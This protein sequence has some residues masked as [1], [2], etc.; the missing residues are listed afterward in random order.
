MSHISSLGAAMFT[1]MSVS[2]PAVNSTAATLKA[3]ST[4]TDFKAFFATQIEAVGGVP[5]AGAFIS[6]PNVRE[7]PSIGIPANIVNV[8]AYGQKNSSQVQGQADAPTL[9]LT[10]NYVPMEWA[11]AT[12][13]VLGKMVGDGI[14]RVFRFSLLNIEPT[15]LASD[16]AG[17]GTVEN[18]QYFW[19]GKLE[20]L[21]VT[22]SLTDASTA[23][24]T[25]SMQSELYGPFTS[26][27]V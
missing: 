12:A 9:E 6:I 1:D 2:A 4:E 26:N 24:L 10:L 7:F 17:L 19:V 22:P 18:S 14:Q 5:A 13:N 11:K 15:G 27:P 25:L 16:A 8:P 3:L 23:T 20:A 21:Q